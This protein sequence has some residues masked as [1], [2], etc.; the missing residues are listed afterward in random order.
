MTEETLPLAENNEEYMD[1][2]RVI[3]EK[4]PL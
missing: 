2:G 1:K 4:T 3:Y